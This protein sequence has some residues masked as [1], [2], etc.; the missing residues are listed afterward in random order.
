MRVIFRLKS[1]RIEELKKVGR[2]SY[3]DKWAPMEEQ[4]NLQRVT[5]TGDFRIG[6]MQTNGGGMGSWHAYQM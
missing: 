2:V 6:M 1:T 3:N 4:N 5:G